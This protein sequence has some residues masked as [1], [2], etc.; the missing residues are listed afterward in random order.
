VSIQYGDVGRAL[1]TLAPSGAVDVLGERIDARSDGAVIEAGTL[2]V[3][4][5]GDPT[6]YVVRKLSPDQTP[7]K[8]PNRGKPIPKAEFQ[9]T[10]AEAAAADRREQA[11]LR[12][13]VRDGLRKGSLT[14]GKLG[15]LFGLACGC[16]GFALGRVGRD[17]PAGIAVLFGL[18]LVTGAAAGVVVFLLISLVSHST[19]GA[20]G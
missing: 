13:R 4:L 20:D 3:V 8:V 10:R 16:I 19:G 14:A 15:A 11:E 2:V 7:P 6:G 9:M 18:S 12:R 5:R 17:D 1:T